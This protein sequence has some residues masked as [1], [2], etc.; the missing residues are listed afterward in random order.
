MWRLHC[1]NLLDQR[2]TKFRYV[3]Y[4]GQFLL[5]LLAPLW[6]NA[7]VYMVLGRMIHFFLDDDK[8]FGMRAR[9]ITLIFVLFDI[10][11]FIVQCAGGA[12]TSG[13]RSQ[14]VLDTG[15][16]IYCGGIG[17]QMAAI[18]IFL[19]ISIR[20]YQHVGAQM[21][22]TTCWR[23]ELS[24]D[25]SQGNSGAA[26]PWDKPSA[27][28]LYGL[29]A[30]LGC[31]LFRNIYRLIEYTLGFHSVIVRH[32]WFNYVF[33]AVP[34]LTAMTLLNVFYPGKVLQG[35]RSGFSAE[36]ESRKLARFEKK[37]AK[38]DAKSARKDAKAARKARP[39][40]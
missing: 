4:V 24:E 29:W 8:V 7:F 30:T 6:I 20:F 2:S 37:G 26:A 10:I 25:T 27:R 34:M 33:D 23:E 39:V 28:L 12:T 38:K 13:Q 11:A 9:R 17:L 14:S 31:I 3:I 18:F 22:S 15:L 5:I 16:G 35:P 1:P 32:E 21:Q 40:S 19:A 36:N